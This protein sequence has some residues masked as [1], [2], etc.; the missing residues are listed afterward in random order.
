MRVAEVESR[1]GGQHASGVADRVA[2][3]G[4]D[5]VKTY[6]EGSTAVTALR[7]VSVDIA[8]SRFTAIMGPSG[9]GKSTLMHCL[10]GLDS[11]TQG[12]IMLGDTVLSSLDDDGRTMLRRQ[13]IGFVFQSLNLLPAFNARQNILLPLD[14]AGGKPDNQWFELL[15]T[16]LGLGDRLGHRP[17][18]LSGGQQQ[19]VAIARALMPRPDVVFADEPT[20]NLDSRSGH[21][22]LTFLQ[23]TVRE[24][25]QTVV[26][27][28]HDPLAAAWADRV[29]ML[30]DGQI[31]RSIDD[32]TPDRV[33]SALGEI[34]D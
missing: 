9:S 12:Q 4:T 23:R 30:A 10:A 6:G 7:G 22:V 21:Q 32:P 24:F 18:E 16:T 8:A 5:L 20:G 33:I 14:L 26:M 15:V 17:S 3:R 29:I 11:V 25:G 28:T 2:L 27:V 19:R 34:G 13:Q 1:F 31:V